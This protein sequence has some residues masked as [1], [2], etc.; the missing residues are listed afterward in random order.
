MTTSGAETDAWH[1]LPLAGVSETL[2]QNAAC[3]RQLTLAG[4][5]VRCRSQIVCK[6][7]MGERGS[8]L[9]GLGSVDV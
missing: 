1:R 3:R 5:W 2:T 9:G 7:K 6:G 4:F 8:G